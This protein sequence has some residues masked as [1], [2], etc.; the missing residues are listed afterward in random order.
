[1][2]ILVHLLRWPGSHW[3]FARGLLSIPEDKIS[4]FLASIREVSSCR[5]V[6]ARMLAQ[7]TGRI[8]C[9]VVF[10]HICKIMTKA[11]H[12]V[13]DSR[14]YWNARVFVTTEAISELNY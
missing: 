13:I 4:V 12:S 11:L 2:W 14:A 5:I 1:M 3:D 7:V 10:G 9:M 6:T 8:I